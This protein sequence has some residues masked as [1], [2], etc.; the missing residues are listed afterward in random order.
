M[1]LSN[2]DKIIGRI[3]YN[4]LY[5]FLESKNLIY[6]LQL[7]FR[8]RHSTSHA[9]IHLT[10]KIREQLD[11]GVL[12]CSVF[13][14]FQKAYYTFCHDIF[15]QKSNYYGVR[16]T[17]N[18][19]FFSFYLEDRTQ[20]LSIN[21]YSSHLHFICCGVLQGSILGLCYLSI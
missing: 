12:G 17:A 10:D 20:F 14:D 15:I 16:V 9:L 2:V 5:E 6:D 18:N 21:G 1:L 11:K 7:G 19:C 4:C 13:G 3:V 8:Q